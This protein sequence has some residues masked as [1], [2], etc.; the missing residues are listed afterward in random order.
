VYAWHPDLTGFPRPADP[1]V[2][3]H[4]YN[5]VVYIAHLDN[6]EYW[7]GWFQ[8]SQPEANWPINQDLN[9]MFTENEGYITF[10]GNVEFD[11]S[12][13]VWPF[14]ITGAAASTPEPTV[15]TRERGEEDEEEKIFFDKDEVSTENATPAFKETMRKI[16]VR[17]AKAVKKLKQLYGNLCQVT[18]AKFTFRKENGEYYSE[19]HH[20]IALGKGGSDS[21]HNIVVVSPLIHRMFHNAKVEGLDLTKIKDNKLPF[22]INGEDYVITYH[23]EHAKIVQEANLSNDADKTDT[24]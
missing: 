15:P 5:L 14:K 16:R 21:V 8:K 13:A 3:S 1:K 7:A 20:L 4:I 10:K 17:N 2:R 9:R 18:G 11:A 19:A 22:K 23:P 24:P 12:D 6:G